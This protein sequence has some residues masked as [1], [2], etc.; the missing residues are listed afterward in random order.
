MNSPPIYIQVYSDE[1]LVHSQQHQKY[2]LDDEE[3]G[4]PCFFI[5]LIVRLM[6]CLHYKIH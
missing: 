1:N 4:K 3:P 2:Y 5:D 6:I